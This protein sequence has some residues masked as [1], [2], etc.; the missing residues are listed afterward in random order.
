MRCQQAEPQCSKLPDSLAAVTARWNCQL[1]E[2]RQWHVDAPGDGGQSKML[3]E[4]ETRGSA[5]YQTPPVDSPTSRSCS[6]CAPQRTAA[7]TLHM[8]TDHQ[9]S[10]KYIF[11]NRSGIKVANIVPPHARSAVDSGLSLLDGTSSC[12]IAA[13]NRYNGNLPPVFR[14]SKN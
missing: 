3:A 11:V 2:L 14:A 6:S 9:L 10:G 7:S 12:L 8:R 1:R 5:G 13:L 4:P